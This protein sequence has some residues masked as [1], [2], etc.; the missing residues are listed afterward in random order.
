[1]VRE[2]SV[3][4]S[5]SSCGSGPG[6]SSS[7]FCGE[8]FPH[9]MS[10][11]RCLRHHPGS[12]SPGD[13]SPGR[14]SVVR[15]DSLIASTLAH[16]VQC[17]VVRSPYLHGGENEETATVYPPFYTHSPHSQ[18]VIRPPFQLVGEGSISQADWNIP[19]VMTNFSRGSPMKSA[20]TNDSTEGKHSPPLQPGKLVVVISCF[21]E[22]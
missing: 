10:D 7:Q 22:P 15:V 13:C 9:T 21:S 6:N 1:M 5:G 19:T 2:R 18:E 12:H 14:F 11:R 4:D 8:R 16:L 3:S 20:K 17:P